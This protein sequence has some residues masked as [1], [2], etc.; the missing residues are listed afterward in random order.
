MDSTSL[1]TRL[2][3]CPSCGAQIQQMAGGRLIRHFDLRGKKAKWCRAKTEAAKTFNRGVRA[4][5]NTLTE[6]DH[7]GQV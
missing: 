4:A 6:G 7:D 2:A 3:E 1:L 5:I